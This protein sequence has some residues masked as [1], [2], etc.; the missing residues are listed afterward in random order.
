MCPQNPVQQVMWKNPLY[1]IVEFLLE[2]GGEIGGHLSDGV[3]CSITDSGVLE[4]RQMVNNKS[5]QGETTT[6][7]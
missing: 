4:K 5:H 2:G 3:A 7:T 1:L 6:S